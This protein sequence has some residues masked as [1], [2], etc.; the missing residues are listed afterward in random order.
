[1]LQLLKPMIVFRKA[2]TRNA[3]AVWNDAAGSSSG[4]NAQ[5]TDF[6]K[7]EYR[8]QVNRQGRPKAEVPDRVRIGDS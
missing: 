7:V 1:M 4:S 5:E 2:A 8:C 6:A 3:P